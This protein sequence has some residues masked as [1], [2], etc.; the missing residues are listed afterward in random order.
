[1]KVNRNSM[2]R[3]TLYIIF[4]FS[5]L[6]NVVFCQELTASTPDSEKLIG[7]RI[8]ETLVNIAIHINGETDFVFFNMHDN[9][10]TSVDASKKYIEENGG[11]L[12]EVKA[13]GDR[14]ITFTLNNINYTFDPNRIFTDVGIKKTLKKH[15]NYSEKA[16]TVVQKFAQFLIN[17]VFM[18]D[19]KAIIAVH[20]NTNGRYSV[21]S[22]STNGVYQNDAES[23]N[24]VESH[25]SDDFFF[26]T[27]RK[28]FESIQDLGFNV[29][30]QNNENVTDDGSLSVYCGQ[31]EIPYIN[32]EAQQGHFDQQLE[33]MEA[34][35][36]IID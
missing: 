36:S 29:A 16:F 22:Y 6:Y 23:V 24:V 25:D 3:N 32:I 19:P 35:P 2:K 15:G 34:I 31:H 4:I 28:Y 7:Y 20:N 26:V 8:G 27:E 30:L 33:M 17:L 13:N 18:D 1:M 12:V 5:L 9:E 11:C 21:K 14:L 10:N